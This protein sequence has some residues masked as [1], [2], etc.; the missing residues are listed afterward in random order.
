[1]VVM[2]VLVIVATALP[3]T[4]AVA[5]VAVAFPTIVTTLLAATVVPN[6]VGA[7]LQFLY[8]RERVIAC[9]D[10]ILGP[11]ALLRGLITNDQIQA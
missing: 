7:E 6:G 10:Q 5:L 11:G 9:N 1:M 2:L 3:L 4:L 8:R